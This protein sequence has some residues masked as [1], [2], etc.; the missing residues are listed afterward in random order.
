MARATAH[1]NHELISSEDVQGTEVYGTGDEKI[2][3]I[4]HL[5]ID[6]LSGRVVYAV[7]SFGGFL[8]IGDDYYPLPWP[9]LKYNVELGG[10]QLAISMDIF[11]G[12]YR[13]GLDKPLAIAP[14]KLPAHALL[15]TG[16]VHH[17]LIREGLR[18]DANIVVETATARDPHQI[19]TLIG[20]G[21][22]AV[23]PYL[24]YECLH[25]MLASGD[26]VGKTASVLAQNYRKGINKGLYKIISKMGIS[27]ITSYRGAQLFEAIGLHNDVIDLC[28]TGTT[29]RVQGAG[30]D[31]LQDDQQCLAREAWTLRKTIQQGGLLKYIHGGEQHAYNPDVV[32]TLQRAV[33]SGDYAHYQEYAALVNHRATLTLRDLL[34][35]RKDVAPVPL[36]EVEP[37]EAILPRFDSAGMSLGALSPEAHEAL[38][39]AMNRLGGRSN[40]GEG[41]EDP[42][43]YGT[44]KMSK[45]KQVASGRF[46]V[47][48]A[49]LVNAEV[50]QIKIAQGA[51]PG[52]GGQ[53][54]GDKVNAL[55]AGL[56]Y[57]RPGVA[58]ISPPPH[59]DI[60]SLEDLAQLIFDLKQVN[61]KALVSVKLVAEPGV[62]TIAAGVAKAYA[63]LITISG[64]D[65]GTGASPLTSIK[66]AGSPWELGLTETHQ[67]LRA[68]NLRDKVRLQTDG[69]LKTGLDVIKAAILGAES[70]GFGTGPMVALGCKYLRICHLNNCATGI[71]TQNDVLRQ[72]HFIGLPEMVM[73]YFRF[74]AR[75]TRELM[76]QLGVRRMSDLIGRTD[77]LQ[78]LEGTTAR[79]HKLDLKPLLSHAGIPASS[80]QY[81]K[82]PRNAPF[83][84][85]ELAEQMVKDTLDAIEHKRGGAF[86]YNVRNIH[87]SIGARLSGEIARRHGDKGME[88]AP[89]TIKLKGAVGQSFGVWNA[90]GLNLILEGDANDYVGKG[91]ASGKLAIYPPRNSTFKS[92]ET[93]IIG[94][95][96]LYGA[97]GGKLFA[98][99]L[100]GER[101][102]V[103]NSGALAVVEGVGDHGCEY[104]TGG[105]IVVLGATGLNFGAG[106][107]G[108]FSYV[109]DND[110]TFVDRYNHELVDIHRI[111]TEPMGGHRNYLRS[112]I[113][114]FV[115]ETGS[116]WGQTLLDD[117]EMY[118][119]KFWLVK[120]K[121]AEIETLLE[122]LRNAA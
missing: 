59:H 11:R 48:P 13:Q 7:M 61:P 106:M 122:T 33:K 69:G 79:Q 3:E 88:S 111:S 38:A 4:D 47:T 15:A 107:T 39:T 114:E 60:Y 18:C 117:F 115:S 118:S 119:D 12:R 17:R 72:V 22:T 41:G 30:F 2:G 8:G 32:Q 70:F 24:A 116:A 104:M 101:F 92:H 23:Y 103:R 100:A 83:D 31:D 20:Y 55:I 91:M 74:I 54:P 25:N 108:G 10:Y 76:A 64:Y 90:G 113:E 71:A 102:A 56:R 35:V 51:K 27:T 14:G 49:Y 58:L 86:S 37:M 28:F 40:S 44:E 9:S 94:N 21:A 85:G 36:D 43:R 53:L 121:A 52:E 89:I 109:M 6:K 110:N 112:L 66:Y 73:N 50:L 93:P 82:E 78:I 63:D 120:P 46:G 57:A 105:V 97:T 5:M 87:R 34:S 29:S 81:C 42:K 68:N 96:C 1:P 84:K 65:G 98:A 80:P 77:L 19:A 95:T 62:G 45:I 99:G 75:E 26:I 67:V 16:A